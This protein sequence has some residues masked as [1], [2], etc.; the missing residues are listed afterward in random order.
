MRCTEHKFSSLC[1][2]PNT[3][4]LFHIN[5]RKPKTAKPEKSAWKVK[6]P[7]VSAVDEH[8]VINYFSGIRELPKFCQTGRSRA[9]VS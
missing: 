1:S 3:D 2:V 4:D 5:E 7:T 8:G 6:S 9:R